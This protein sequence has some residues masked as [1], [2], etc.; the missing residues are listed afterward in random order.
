VTPRTSEGF[1]VLLI[2]RNPDP[3]S[4]LPYLLRLPL[5][6]RCGPQGKGDLAPGIPSVLPPL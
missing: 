3:D 4:K 6:G 5:E 1:P 2:A